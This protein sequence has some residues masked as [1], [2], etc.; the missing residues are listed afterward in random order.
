[1]NNPRVS[2]RVRIIDARIIAV[3]LYFSDVK[4]CLYQL[5][6]SSP[7]KLSSAKFLVCFNFLSAP[8][9]LKVEENVVCCRTAWI[10]VRRRDTRRLIQIQ[11]VCIWDYSYAW[12]SKGFF[13]QR[14]LHNTR[15]FHLRSAFFGT[16]S[17]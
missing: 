11:A 17:I 14:R 7:N 9:S 8:T 5:T 6:L 3:L 1:M 2:H 4:M 16:Q 12:R 10:R 13:I 15:G